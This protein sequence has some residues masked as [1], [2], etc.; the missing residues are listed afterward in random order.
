MAQS[1]VAELRQTLMALAEA[2]SEAG[3]R[4]TPDQVMAKGHELNPGRHGTFISPPLRH[5]LVLFILFI[6]VCVPCPLF[7]K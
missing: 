7:M 5:G 6:V 4:F 2:L 3:R 1:T